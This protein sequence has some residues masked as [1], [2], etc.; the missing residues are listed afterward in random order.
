ME[1][2]EKPTEENTDVK[3]WTSK[4]RDSEKLLCSLSHTN[5]CLNI[6]ESDLPKNCFYTGPLGLGKMIAQDFAAQNKA[7][8]LKLPGP[9]LVQIYIQDGAEMKRDVFELVREKTNYYMTNSMQLKPKGSTLISL[10]RGNSK[11]LC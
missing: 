2:N 9:P 6:L 5:I 8:L 3:G 4:W 1:L 7:S 10:E 11:E